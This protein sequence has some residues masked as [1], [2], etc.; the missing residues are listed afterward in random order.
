MHPRS[1]V[2]PL[3]VVNTK[4]QVPN[5]IYILHELKAQV[6][7]RLCLNRLTNQKLSNWY[8]N[9]LSVIKLATLKY[10]FSIC[11]HFKRIVASKFEDQITLL[12]VFTQRA[13]L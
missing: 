10:Y 1:I 7:T 9:K 11:S 5:M 13:L 3:K 12:F 8:I 2:N 4:Q 6:G